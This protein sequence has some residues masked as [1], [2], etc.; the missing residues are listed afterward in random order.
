M[1]HI[2][3]VRQ[4]SPYSVSVATPPETWERVA[5]AWLASFSSVNTQDAY[6]RDL[7]RFVEWLTGEGVTDPLRVHRSMLD[8]WARTLEQ[9]GLSAATRARRLAAVSSFYRYA[10]AENLVEY[11]PAAHVRRPKVSG[12]SPRLG[13]SKDEARQVVALARR[14][15]PAHRALLGLTLGVGL[16]VSEAL[17][18]TPADVTTE[19]G[20]RV[21]KV[22]G[23]G[24]KVRTVPVSPMVAEL[25]AD[26]LA[27]CPPG[28]TVVHDPDGSRLTRWAALRMIE[29]LGKDAGIARLRPHDCRHTA[30]TLALDAGAPIH[31]VQDMLGHSS[32]T[33]TQRYVAHR[34]RL[35]GSAVYVLADVL[36]ETGV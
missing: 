10:L 27:A 18:V 9:A 3:I 4:T 25:L 24:G 11:S 29:W 26:A 2:G 1:A 32:P 19:G 30:A 16:R 34:Q 15:S 13:M 14:S 28:C 36:A 21:V 33:T 23:K 7:L 20:H 17:A 8:A 5:G 35:D 31:R 12:D 6:R 22:A